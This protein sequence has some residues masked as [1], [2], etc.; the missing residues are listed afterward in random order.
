MYGALIKNKWGKDIIYGAEEGYLFVKKVTVTLS[1]SASSINVP[2]GINTDMAICFFN[3]TSTSQRLDSTGS[4]IHQSY[5]CIPKFSKSGVGSWSVS[6]VQSKGV[7]TFDCYVFAPAKDIPLPRYGLMIKN[8][9]GL[10]AFHTASE[11][12][13]VNGFINVYG[14]AVNASKPAIPSSPLGVAIGYDG[15]IGSYSVS[16]VQ[17]VAFRGGCRK[18]QGVDRLF[19]YPS[20]GYNASRNLQVPYID[21]SQYD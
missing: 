10:L 5:T 7:N 3:L 19:P 1:G 14:Q 20:R 2:L 18:V 21:A 8:R 4:N 17:L 12:L 9:M 16:F 15:G 11:P 13:K 6:C